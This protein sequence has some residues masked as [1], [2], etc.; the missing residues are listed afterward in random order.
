MRKNL[1][2]LN[3]VVLEN[4]NRNINGE[5]TYSLMP[6]NQSSL[7]MIIFKTQYDEE[8]VPF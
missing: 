2:H 3:F 6:K 8:F 1:K 7:R 5:F 4:L